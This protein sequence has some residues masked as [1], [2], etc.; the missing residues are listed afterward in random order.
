LC[1]LQTIIT[2]VITNYRFTSTDN[3]RTVAIC[4]GGDCSK[5]FTTIS[6]KTCTEHVHNLSSAVPPQYALNSPGSISQ[7]QFHLH[8]LTI[9]CLQNIQTRFKFPDYRRNIPIVNHGTAR[10]VED[11]TRNDRR[12]ASRNPEWW[13]DFS[14]LVEIEKIKFIGISR[15]KFTLRF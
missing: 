6:S 2:V 13:G 12:N 1:Q 9:V 8:L 4:R 14:Q 11:E 3:L 5:P 7:Q 10:S 15:Y